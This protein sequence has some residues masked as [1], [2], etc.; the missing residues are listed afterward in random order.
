MTSKRER[1]EDAGRWLKKARE[2]RGFSTATTFAA[3]LGVNQSMVSR[4]ERGM[5]EVEDERAEQ[6]ADVLG[7]PL[8]EVRRGLGLWVPADEPPSITVPGSFEQ[9]LRE[10]LAQ[11]REDLADLDPSRKVS[12]RILRRALEREIDDVEDRLRQLQILREISESGAETGS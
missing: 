5:S 10:E 2:D 4:Y 9:Q 1:L 12:Y 8:V 3:A 11:L 6:I 7:M